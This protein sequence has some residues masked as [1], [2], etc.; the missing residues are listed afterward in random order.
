M[1]TYSTTELVDIAKQ[2]ERAGEAYY[3]AAAAKATTQKLKEI[4]LFLKEEEVNHA[5]TFEEMLGSLEV[6]Q[7]WR[8]D[9]DYQAYLAA[10]I[11]SRVFPDPAGA[12]ALVER[13]DDEVE[14][15]RHA[16]TFEKDTILFFYYLKPFVSKDD[17]VI[18]QLI[19][20]EKKHIR[21]L[22]AILKDIAPE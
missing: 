19:D 12:V 11:D 15:I 16:I 2:I 21:L 4:F 6:E 10:L 22:S 9:E 1:T 17:E 5:D 7:D 18:D 3:A 13:L 14:A 20:E 8:A